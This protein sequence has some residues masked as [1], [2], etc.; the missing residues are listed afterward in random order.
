MTTNELYYHLTGNTLAQM[1][2]A[3]TLGG[4]ASQIEASKVLTA[5][6]ANYGESEFK[7]LVDAVSASAKTMGYE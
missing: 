5:G 3:L 4:E 6:I 1:Y 2:Y 7:A